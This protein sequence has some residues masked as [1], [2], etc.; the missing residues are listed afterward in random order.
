MTEPRSPDPRGATSG[1][2][3][4]PHW[5]A[6]ARLYDLEHYLFDEMSARFRDDGTR[7]TLLRRV[8]EGLPGLPRSF[9]AMAPEYLHYRDACQAFDPERDNGCRGSGY[10]CSS[11]P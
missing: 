4:G 11:G 6:L 5:R 2:D 8:A 9:A 3:D 7:S 1:G 10:T